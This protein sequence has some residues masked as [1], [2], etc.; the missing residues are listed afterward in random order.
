MKQAKGPIESEDTESH[1]LKGRML[2][3]NF[4]RLGSTHIRLL[5]E[6]LGLSTLS[7]TEELRPLIEG[8][9]IEQEQKPCNVQVVVHE[10]F[11]IE[12]CLFLV[13]VSGPFQQSAPYVQN[14]LQMVLENRCS[15]YLLFF[16]KSRRKKLGMSNRN[17]S[18]RKRN[19]IAR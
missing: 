6:S 4:R 18:R 12:M 3:L 16:L 17:F 2:P 14:D 13:D 1:I 11:N 15:R 10:S 7:S 5:S 8:K 9:L 19:Q